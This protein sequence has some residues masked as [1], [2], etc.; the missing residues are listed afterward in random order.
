[1]IL[2]YAD[3]PR[4]PPGVGDF[5]T[6]IIRPNVVFQNRQTNINSMNIAA[7]NKPQAMANAMAS[8]SGSLIV[9]GLPPSSAGQSTAH[10]VRGEGVLAAC[11]DTPSTRCGT[12][13]LT[14]ELIH[15]RL[16]T[17]YGLSPHLTLVHDH[18]GL[19]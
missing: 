6:N 18:S 4:L 7:A 11:R 16:P 15:R 1:M 8:Q 2:P 12:T 10:S 9:L 13:V 5:Y 17:L 14:S 19:M 3:R